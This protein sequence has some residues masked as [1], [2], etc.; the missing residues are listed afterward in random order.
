VG[1]DPRIVAAIGDAA[2]RLGFLGDA[3]PK[4]DGIYDLRL[5]NAVLREKGLK[6]VD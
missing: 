4:L 1:P 6:T 2:F 5:L 3:P